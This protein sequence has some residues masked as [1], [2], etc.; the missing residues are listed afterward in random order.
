M[1]SATMAAIL[2]RG[3]QASTW[4]MMTQVAGWH[5]NWSR[6]FGQLTYAYSYQMFLA[7]S[8]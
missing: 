1:S 5:E 7:I 6:D 8:T 3:K 4:T 2:F